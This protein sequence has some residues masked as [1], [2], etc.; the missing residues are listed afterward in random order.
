MQVE[1]TSLP[2]CLEIHP[3]VFGDSRGAFAKLYQDTL[4]RERGLE[5]RFPEWACSRSVK[6][7]VRGLHFQLPPKAQDKLVYCLS[8]QVLDAVVDLRKGSPTYGQFETFTLDDKDFRAVLVPKGFGHGFA[9][10]SDVAVVSY[11]MSDEFS[12]EH[13]AGVR[14]NSVPIPWPHA[15]PIL[16]DRDKTLPLFEDFDSPWTFSE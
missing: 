15:D 2:G 3:P 12:P 11:L 14:W 5:T 6:G 4:F 16:S 8:G 10:V 1:E 9:A 13:D 7:V